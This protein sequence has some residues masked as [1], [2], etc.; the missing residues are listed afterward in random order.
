MLAESSPLAA[1]RVSRA[2][3]ATP[4]V[5]LIGAAE[6][7][8]QKATACGDWLRASELYENAASSCCP[9]SA[10][11]LRLHRQAR[12]ARTMYQR[13]QRLGLET[14]FIKRGRA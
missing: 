13:L 3:K 10:E 9:D 11:A 12:V 4:E 2:K 7:A 6:I 8:A 1:K 5:K 14:A